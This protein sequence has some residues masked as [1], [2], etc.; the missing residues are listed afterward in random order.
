MLLPR[1]HQNGTAPGASPGQAPQQSLDAAQDAQE[2][3]D[4]LLR[5]L[6]TLADDAKEDAVLNALPALAPLDAISWMRLKR[7][8]KAAVPALNLNDL[9]R[10]RNE[11]RRTAA[12]QV[13]TF[14]GSAQAQI[15]A[16][17]AQ[18][19]TG[20]LTYETSRKAWMT[21]A[22]GL[23][24]PIDIEYIQQC[25]ALYMDTVL[26]GDYTW[27]DLSGVERLL[28]RRLAQTLT[29]E[30]AGWLPFRNGALHLGTMTFHAHSPERPFTWQLPYN[31]D[32]QATCPKTQAWMHETVGS[33]HDQVQVLRGYAKAVVTRRVDLQR[34]LETIGP[35]GTGKGTYDRLLQGLVGIE[36]TLATELKYLETNRFETSNLRSKVLMVVTDAERYSGPVNQLKA[37]TG[38]D[39]VRME[40]KFKAQRTE[41]APVMVLIAA[42]EPIQSADYTSGLVR[43]RLSMPFR[44]RPEAPRDLLSWQDGTWHGELAPEI[45]GVLNWVLALPDAQMEALIRDTTTHVPSLTLTWAQS[46]VET[47]PLADWAN[48]ALIHDPEP[49]A[50]G[51]VP[52]TN[53][54]YAQRL[55][56]GLGYIHQGD[57]LYPHYV[58]WTEVTGN[59][60]LAS[61]RF[62]GLLKDLLETQLRLTGVMH[63]HDKEGSR[64]H[65]IRLRRGWET[66]DLLITKGQIPENPA[67]MKDVVDTGMAEPRM[68]EECDGCDGFLQLLHKHLSPCVLAEG[69][70]SQKGGGVP[71]ER[72]NAQNPSDPSHSSSARQNGVPDPSPSVAE[73][74][75]AEPPAVGDLVWLFSADG[76]QQNVDPYLIIAIETGSDAQAYARFLETG[77]GWLLSQCVRAELPES[78]IGSPAFTT[79]RL[80]DP[81][82]G[83]CKTNV[84]YRTLPQ[85]DGSEVYRCTTCNTKVGS[86][87]P[88][89]ANSTNASDAPDSLE[90]VI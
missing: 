59:K 30:P 66:D 19:Y 72:V 84:S 51:K 4:A 46:V 60:P 25:V 11:L 9:E 33:A 28:G 2:D 27:N 52:S 78:P 82:C 12:P 6:P 1:R 15:A 50:E 63:L 8:L 68:D 55:D 74:P 18:Q 85:G 86:K 77:T 83:V 89:V 35:G 36:N 13:A 34:Y 73:P 64:F 62:T 45:P 29:L 56:R 53:V 54:G 20:R 10:A 44:H 17:L 39:F 31:Y 48:H 43:R 24:T 88:P 49:D 32:P 37:I 40:E 79:L 90:V 21:Y 80:T 76:V 23:W 22:N 14:S 87:A 75:S 26:Q 41:I 67:L 42:N 47:N 65:G 70:Q 81:W 71:I 3:P 5:K 58:A 57:W 16:A 69:N 7:Q 38:Q 61:R